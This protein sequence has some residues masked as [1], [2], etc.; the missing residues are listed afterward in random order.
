MSM[1]RFVLRKINVIHNSL[2]KSWSVRRSNEGASLP[3]STVQT[4]A[5]LQLNEAGGFLCWLVFIVILLLFIILLYC[6][7]FI[8]LLGWE[9]RTSYGLPLS[10]G[11]VITVG[12]PISVKFFP[13][14]KKSYYQKPKY[15]ATIHFSHNGADGEVEFYCNRATY[16]RSKIAKKIRNLARKKINLSG[17]NLDTDIVKKICQKDPKNL[18]NKLSS[19]TQKNNWIE[20]QFDNGIYNE[21]YTCFVNWH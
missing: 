16:K 8:I 14:I 5:K 18:Y 1:L 13:K 19:A 4:K 2:T 20:L 9:L 17:G 11:V 15:V 10:V 21:I 7:I 6:I 3:Q 12:V